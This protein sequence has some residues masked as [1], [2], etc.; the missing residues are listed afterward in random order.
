MRVGCLMR[1]SKSSILLIYIP[2]IIE[3]ITPPLIFTPPR[4]LPYFTCFTGTIVPLFFHP[5]P[6]FTGVIFSIIYG[7]HLNPIHTFI[8]MYVCRWGV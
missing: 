8:C 2:Y 4:A 7:I 6:L 1:L 3:K 5:P